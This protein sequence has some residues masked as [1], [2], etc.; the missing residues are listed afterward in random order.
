M[1]FQPIVDIRRGCVFAYEALVRGPD[2]Q[3]AGEVLAAVG[4]SERYGFDQACRV[5]AISLAARL[6]LIDT[7][8]MLSINFLPNAVYRPETCI[9]ATLRVARETKLPTE[10]IMFEITE[11]EKVKDREHLK[12]IVEAY[13]KMGFTTAIDDFGAGYAGLSLLAGFQP[14][15]LKVDMELTRNIEQSQVRQAIVENLAGLCR[16]LGI[17]LVAEGIESLGELAFLERIGIELFQGYLFAK[18]RFEA[19]P[20]VDWPAHFGHETSDE[21][22]SLRVADRRNG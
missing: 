6:G 4:D 11:V 16:Q 19:L 21:T 3:P 13:R 20:S 10:R 15:I 14:D 9:Q 7:G 22:I 2:G 12:G 1:A 17:R 5:K 8:A 18:P